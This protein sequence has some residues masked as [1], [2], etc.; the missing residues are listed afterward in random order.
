MLTPSPGASRL[1]S[2]NFAHASANCPASVSALAALKSAS[3]RATSSFDCALAAAGASTATSPAAGDEPASHQSRPPNPLVLAGF[4]VVAAGGGVVAAV[5]VLTARVVAGLPLGGERP[6]A[7]VATAAAVAVA[8]AV[9]DGAATRRRIGSRCARRKERPTQPR[10]RE[11]ARVSVS[12]RS[13]APPCA[14]RVTTITP[15]PDRRDRE[16]DPGHDQQGRRPLRALRVAHRPELRA[17]LHDP[18]GRRRR[19]GRRDPLASAR[20]SG[21]LAPLD[22]TTRAMRSAIARDV[23]RRPASGASAC[24]ERTRRPESGARVLLEAAHH[25]GR[26]APAELWPSSAAATEARPGC[27][28]TPRAACRRRTATAR[29]AS[30]RG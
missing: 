15:D 1:L 13:T 22:R 12:P 7:A 29:R 9:A 20:M 10:P 27:A 21:R 26:R 11:A 8:D 2:A 19:H 5:A 3:A 18:R 23:G 4:A 24:G 17:R 6:G 16:R 25:H 14:C 30:R 28:R